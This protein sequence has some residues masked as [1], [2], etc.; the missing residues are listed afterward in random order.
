M[1]DREVTIIETDR[2][3]ARVAHLHHIKDAEILPRY[4]RYVEEHKSE[5]GP[6][7]PPLLDD[8]ILHTFLALVDGEAAGTIILRRVDDKLELKRLSVDPKFRGLGLAKRL[9]ARCEDIARSLGDNLLWLHTGTLQPEAINLYSSTG[10]E[11]LEE[12]FAPYREDG[13]AV[14]FKKQL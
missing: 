2:H 4:Q 10:W 6:Y 3:D 13:F 14:C 1:T 5:Q 9:I 7:E 11:R 8:Q 12:P